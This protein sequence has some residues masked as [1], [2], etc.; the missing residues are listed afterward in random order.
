MK[1]T[2]VLVLAALVPVPS[3]GDESP[4][5]K[6]IAKEDEAKSEISEKVKKVLEVLEQCRE[7]DNKGRLEE[8]EALKSGKR[9]SVH[10]PKE[11]ET[12]KQYDKFYADNPALRKFEPSPRGRIENERARAKAASADAAK[13]TQLEIKRLQAEG[14][15]RSERIFIPVYGYAAIED[16]LFKEKILSAGSSLKTDGPNLGVDSIGIY[17]GV[18]TITRILNATHALATI[19]NKY[20]NGVEEVCLEQD[21]TKIKPGSQVQLDP[22]QLHYAVVQKFTYLNDANLP[23]PIRDRPLVVIAR[24]P[25]T[26]EE[27]TSAW[28]KLQ[29]KDPAGKE[30]ESENTAARKLELAKSMLNRNPSAGRT[31]LKAIVTE[32]PGTR[33][34]AEAREVLG[35][36]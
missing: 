28:E 7:I 18:F 20:K 6:T 31:Q 14:R 21:T 15:K 2:H 13:Q 32:F 35:K 4:A 29:K 23:L 33:A 5:P 16:L 1:L 19:P 26:I 9:T 17:T 11:A 30:I 12:M 27:V 8:I 34:A 3:W 10:A 36:N 24:Y 22:N 25:V